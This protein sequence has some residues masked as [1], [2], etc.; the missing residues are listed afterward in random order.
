MQPTGYYEQIRLC[1]TQAWDRLT[2]PS[3][4]ED[5]VSSLLF[6]LQKPGKPLSDFILRTRMSLERKILNPTDRDLKNIV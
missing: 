4:L 1:A 2:P 5:P 3:V 6:L